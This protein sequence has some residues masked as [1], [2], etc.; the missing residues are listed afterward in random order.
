MSYRLDLDAPIAD[1]L[2]AAA[3]DQLRDGAAELRGANSSE[4]VVGAIHQAR[5]NIKKTRSL[6][7]LARSG[8]P[9][10]TCREENGALRDIARSLSDERDAAVLLQTFDGLSVHLVGLMPE[11]AVAD[12]RLRLPGSDG[13]AARKRWR[14][15]ARDAAGALEAVADR[16][17]G[18][19]LEGCDEGALKAGIKRSYARGRRAFSVAAQDPTVERQHEWRK[20][21]KDLWYHQRLLAMAWPGMLY[22][23]AEQSHRLSD[24]LGEDHDLA[25]LAATLLGEDGTASGTPADVE[26]SLEHV[27][28]ERRAEL[29]AQAL[30]LAERI[31]SERPKAYARRLAGYVHTARSARPK[32][33]AHLG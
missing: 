22:A 18:W 8:L 29:Q 23:Q 33:S 32:G 25:M 4:D 17:L 3:S 16:V 5:K 28:A 19:P 20:R 13:A 21:A 14:G 12:L 7:R 1:A 11:Q 15:L 30:D 10:E 6:L 9:G 2:R 27:L 24:L 26:P 31:Y